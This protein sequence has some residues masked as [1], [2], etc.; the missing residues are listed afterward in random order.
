MAKTEWASEFLASRFVVHFFY[1][2]HQLS[3]TNTSELR[4]QYAIFLILN[5]SSLRK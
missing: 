3:W 1:G 5:H 2:A 4:T